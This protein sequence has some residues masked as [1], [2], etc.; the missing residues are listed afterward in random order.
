MLVLHERNRIRQTHQLIRVGLGNQKNW[1]LQVNKNS[2]IN[3]SSR[4]SHNNNTVIDVTS[5][6][7]LWS[8]RINHKILVLH[9]RNRI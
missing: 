1:F 4:M 3:L 8:C 6:L 2:A 7:R 5:L 9:E